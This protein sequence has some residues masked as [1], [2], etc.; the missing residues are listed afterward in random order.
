MHEPAKDHVMNVIPEQLGPDT[1]NGS[2]KRPKLKMCWHCGKDINGNNCLACRDGLKIRLLEAD[3]AIQTECARQSNDLA[4]NRVA[5][6][7]RL[8]KE[9]EGIQEND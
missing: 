1:S 3:L 6:V 5:E 2:W 9:N 4:Q 8:M 7:D